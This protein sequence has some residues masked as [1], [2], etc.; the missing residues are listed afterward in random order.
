MFFDR[1]KRSTAH[2]DVRVVLFSLGAVLAL[3]GMAWSRRWL[4]WIAVGILILGY[5]ARFLDRGGD[6]DAD[7]TGGEDEGRDE[8]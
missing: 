7:A 4:V 5:A 6:G 8:V 2:L 3:V 1:R